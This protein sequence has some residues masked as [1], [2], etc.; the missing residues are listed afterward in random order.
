MACEVLPVAMFLFLLL[1]IYNLATIGAVAGGFD[2]FLIFWA[3]LM[4]HGPVSWLSSGHLLRMRPQKHHRHQ[5]PMIP[6][7]QNP[8]KRRQ[9]VLFSD[10]LIQVS[11]CIGGVCLA[12]KVG[13]CQ[14]QFVT[15][16]GKRLEKSA[17]P[18]QFKH[19]QY[20]RS[21][22]FQARSFPGISERTDEN[23]AKKIG[24]YRIQGS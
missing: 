1:T 10:L 4:S 19:I 11:D 6:P 20:N 8:E 15:Q 5:Q 12:W 9:I 13:N 24:Q 3:A 23:S 7:L 22:S 2:N 18:C 16:D 14:L 17:I 21:D